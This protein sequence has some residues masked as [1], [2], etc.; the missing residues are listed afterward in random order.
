MSYTLQSGVTISST[1]HAH[2]KN[3]SL[4][5]NENDSISSW[6]DSS[7]NGHHATQS[8]AA[9]QPVVSVADTWKE[10]PVGT[11]YA[12][13]SGSQSLSCTLTTNITDEPVTI[14]VV[15]KNRRT[16]SYGYFC[17]AVSYTHLTLPTTPYV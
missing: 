16:S 6:L 7:G 12:S 17:S 14:F 4:P 11:K 5:A 15:G 9:N 2:Y 13:F 3:E 10:L 1:P 8:T